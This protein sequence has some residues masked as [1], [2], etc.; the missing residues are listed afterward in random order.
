MISA[1]ISVHLHF[2]DKKHNIILSDGKEFKIK[3]FRVPTCLYLL[4][5]IVDILTYTSAPSLV[6]TEQIY[7]GVPQTYP[8][9]GISH[10][11]MKKNQTTDVWMKGFYI[12][13]LIC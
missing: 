12:A 10:A 2:K 4:V 7:C 6:I 11:P 13:L 5:E 1:N 8:A 3:R 9:T